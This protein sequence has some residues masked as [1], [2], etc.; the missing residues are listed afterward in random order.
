MCGLLFIS[1]RNPE[2]IGADQARAALALQAWRGPDATE[3][4]SLHDG[5]VHLGHNRL[6]IIDP[7]ARANQPMRSANGRYTIVFNGEVYNHA[8]LRQ[9]FDLP[10]RTRSDTEVLLEGYAAHGEAFFQHL[11]GMYAFV[12]ADSWEQRW[13]AVRDPL[14]IKPLFLRQQ[15]D[16][17]CVASE[18]RVVA[19]L[20]GA[21]VDAQAIAE[22]RLIR[23]PMPGASFFEGVQEVLPGTVRRSDGSVST[24][25]ALQAGDHPFVQADFEDLLTQVVHEHETSDVRNVALL[26]GGIDSALVLAL[27][28]VPRAYSVGLPDNNEFAPAADTAQQLGRELRCITLDA[29]NLTERWQALTRLRGEPLAVPNEALIHHVCQAMDPDEKVVLTGEGADELVFGYDRLCRWAA[30]ATHWTLPQ[31]L[32]HYAYADLAPTPRLLDH[33][34]TMAQG[35]SAIEFVEDFLYQ[36]HLPGL[37]RRMDFAAMAASREARVPF[38]D[39]RLV[40]YCYRQPVAARMDASHAK[41]PLRQALSARGL[42]GPLQRPKIGFSAQA[43]PGVHRHTEYEHFQ[44]T[45]LKE[46]SWS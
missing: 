37:L 7:Q 42:M 32:G 29:S 45:V 44:A 43:T 12:I 13:I 1:Q 38:A 30:Q 31:F 17:T 21:A 39:R 16:T 40:A 10:S 41:T 36:V 5:R 23:R 24:H 22:W 28:Q 14:G 27:S 18:A 11:E 2:G 4:L 15:G 8:A 3:L 35:R 9:R 25:W 20:T 19:H 6:A 34:M 26:S 33:L 46:L